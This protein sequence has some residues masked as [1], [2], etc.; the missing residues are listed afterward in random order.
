MTNVTVDERDKNKIN[1]LGYSIDF[2]TKK[3]NGHSELRTTRWTM[4]IL[5]KT[6]L[7]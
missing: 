5:L 2:T 7:K 6:G 1:I 4:H 3:I